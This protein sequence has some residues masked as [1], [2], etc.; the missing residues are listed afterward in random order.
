MSLRIHIVAVAVASVVCQVRVAE[1]A[2]SRAPIEGPEPAPLRAAGPS[3]ERTNVAGRQG[4]GLIA[5]GALVS[6]LGLAANLVRV[7]QARRL[8]D[9]VSYDAATRTV[10]GADLCF[11]DTQVMLFLG[12]GALVLNVAGFGLV[13]AGAHVHGRWAA[14]WRP[15]PD[16]LPRRGGAQIAVGAAVLAGG[17]LGYGVT[18]VASYVDMLGF[19]TCSA[20]HGLG[21]DAPDPS[22]SPLTGCVRER[23]GGY[24]LG[25]T[26]TQL[27]SI[28]GV[29]VL[30]HG[31]SFRR[32]SRAY[33]FAAS[34]R[35]RLRPV[36]S[37]LWSGVSLS[38]SF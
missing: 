5:A 26:L 2:V 7:V 19:N 16:R 20:R 12:P 30:A 3:A 1:A 21:L 24:L 17:L 31:A 9:A 4:A 10:S 36:L 13:A 32:H 22:H 35:L 33:E 38:G 23:L 28:V 8:C 6:G 34:H 15:D 27:V 25:I 11:S 18:R 37:P 14:Q 29:G